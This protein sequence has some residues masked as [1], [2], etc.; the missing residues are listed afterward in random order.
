M[1]RCASSQE[2]LRRRNNEWSLLK[3]STR[4]LRTDPPFDIGTPKAPELADLHAANLAASCHSLQ[5][6][7]V[8]PQDRG[9]LIAIQHPLYTPFDA[10]EGAATDPGG[11]FISSAFPPRVLPSLVC[12]SIIMGPPS[13]PTVT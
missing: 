3:S 9:G 4:Q 5:R 1:G 7:G 8:N 12:H 2:F 13:L 6:L 10:W 11:F